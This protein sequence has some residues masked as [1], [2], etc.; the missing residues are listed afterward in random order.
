MSLDHAAEVLAA[1]LARTGE[2]LADRYRAWTDGRVTPRATVAELDALFDGTLDADGVGL[3]E[4]LAFTAD[5]VLPRCLGIPHPRYWGL[6]NSSP[7]PEA[8]VADALVS[9]V[10]NNGGARGQSPA[11]TSAEREVIR[12]FKRAF[13]VGDDWGGLILP[14]GSFASLQAMHLARERHLPQWTRDGAHTLTGAPRVYTSE[15]SHFSVGR[16][17][18]VLGVATDDVV[19][20]PSGGPRGELDPAA[21]DAL[22]TADRARGA[23]PFCVNAT[24]GATGTG[25]LDDLEALADVCAEHDVWL[26]VDACYGGSAV[27]VDELRDAFAGAERAQ[28]L[29]VDPHKWCFVPVTA[30][31]LLVAD[32]SLPVRVY[33]VDASYVPDEAEP[34][35]YRRGLATSRRAMGFTT[36]FTLRA[37]GAARIAQI[38]DDNCRQARR[39]EARLAEAGFDVLPDG[40]LSTTCARWEPAGL[41]AAALDDVQRR[42]AAA[43]VDGGDAWLATTRHEG[44]IWLRA[45]ITNIHT[46]DADVE[47]VADVVIDAARALAST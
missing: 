19:T 44:R 15:V 6:V 20:V 11:F 31:V 4:A 21:L 34:D 22:L 43:V 25:A 17:A 10:N 13:G 32:P 38:V 42:I 1:Q 36:W 40:R 8:V 2:L 5:E 18:R 9:G 7:L 37:V 39:F 28:S 14:G 16:A 46:T 47:R 45:A 29:T 3:D 24:S 26:H 27:L 35:P 30:G 23:L 12:F 33:D 41:D